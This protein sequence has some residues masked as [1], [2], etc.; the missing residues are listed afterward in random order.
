MSTSDFLHSSR[1]LPVISGEALQDWLGSLAE[2]Q[3]GNWSLCPRPHTHCTGE[4]L[5]MA[6][7]D[8]AC[9]DF[10]EITSDPRTL[11]AKDIKEHQRGDY[12]HLYV[13][14]LVAFAVKRGVLDGDSVV[15]YHAW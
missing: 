2:F 14:H 5:Y 7:V 3:V 15:V 13:D 6:L 9:S 10:P 1:P 8:G 12:H 4:S 11:L